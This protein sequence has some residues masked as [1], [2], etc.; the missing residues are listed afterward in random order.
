VTIEVGAAVVA[1][2]PELLVPGSTV[3]TG[4]IVIKGSVLT[5]DRVLMTLYI[6]DL[7]DG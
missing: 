1:V 2:V 6:P 4:F 7:H 3:G 5:G